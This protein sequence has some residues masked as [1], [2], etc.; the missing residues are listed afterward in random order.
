MQNFD[1][2]VC[3][4]EIPDQLQ[5]VRYIVHFEA[6]NVLLTVRLW[7]EKLY[8]VIFNVNLTVKYILEKCNI[9]LTGN[10]II[11]M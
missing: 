2:F 7:P 3:S 5:L 1:K 10:S 6:T 8:T 9:Y 4:C 11:V